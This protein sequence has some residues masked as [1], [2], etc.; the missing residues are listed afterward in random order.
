MSAT[1]LDVKTVGEKFG[2]ITPDILKTKLVQK[3]NQEGGFDASKE[4]ERVFG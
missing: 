1:D 2:S 3:Q 4:T